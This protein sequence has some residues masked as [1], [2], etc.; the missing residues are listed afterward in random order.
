MTIIQGEM[1]DDHTDFT[2]LCYFLRPEERLQ[3]FDL[4]CDVIQKRVPERVSLE[5][6]VKRPNVYPYMKGR[7][8]RLVPNA[9]TTAKI[10]NA[11]R[12]KACNKVILSLLEP[13][14]ER[15]RISAK[16]YQKWIRGMKRVYS[17]FSE[18]EIERLE[19]SLSPRWMHF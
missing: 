12:Y 18:G 8:K 1:L 11:L 10:I 15:M 7:K 14:V 6:G 4:L 9:E 19:W 2:S 5:L 13:A 16:A 3:L 17:L